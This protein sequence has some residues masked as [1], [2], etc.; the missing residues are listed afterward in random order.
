MAWTSGILRL[1]R[2]V[3]YEAAL[4][5]EMEEHLGYSNER[6]IGDHGEVRIETPRDPSKAMSAAIM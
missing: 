4:G 5:T 3:T 1:L 2:K 6:L